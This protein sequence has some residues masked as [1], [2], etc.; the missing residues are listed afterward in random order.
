[1]AVTFRR[2]SK[3]LADILKSDAVRDVI[4]A[5]AEEVASA[6]RARQRDVDVV[7]DDYTTDRAASSVTIRDPLA[8]EMQ[9]RDG[10]L[11]AAAAAAGLEVRAK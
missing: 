1:M 8:Q 3:G 6:V 5:E 7:V 2:D 11:T 10:I 9:A 4:H